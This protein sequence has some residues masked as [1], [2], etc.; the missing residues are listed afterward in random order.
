MYRGSSG[1]PG[2]RRE[3]G[4]YREERGGELPRPESASDCGLDRD[5][6]LERLSRDVLGD[7]GEGDLDTAE[8]GE[9]AAST[10]G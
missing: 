7:W 10:L 5:D 4:E 9:A 6:F 1:E 8:A 3:R 2:E